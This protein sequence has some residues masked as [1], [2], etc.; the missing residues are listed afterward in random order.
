MREIFEKRMQERQQFLD[1]YFVFRDGPPV[2]FDPGHGHGALGELRAS[3]REIAERRRLE[4]QVPQTVVASHDPRPPLE[5]P[6]SP[7]GVAAT[8]GAAPPATPATPLHVAAPPR[9]VERVEK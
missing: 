7:L 5:M 2:G 6:S 8:Q 9:T 3:Y 4:S 1:H